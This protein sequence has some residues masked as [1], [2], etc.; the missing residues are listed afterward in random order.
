VRFRTLAWLAA[1]IAAFTAGAKVGVKY[2]KDNYVVR[3]RKFIEGNA[4][5]EE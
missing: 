4:V 1:I 3:D 5:D 2:A